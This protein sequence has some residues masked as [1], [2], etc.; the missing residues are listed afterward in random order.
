MSVSLT[1]SG[2]AACKQL[3]VLKT[4]IIKNANRVLNETM[5]AKINDLNELFTS[6]PDFNLEQSTVEQV[7]SKAC[8][9]GSS[10]EIDVPMTADEG[11][12]NNKKRKLSEISSSLSSDDL[13]NSIHISKFPRSTKKVTTNSVSVRLE[14]FV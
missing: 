4:R 10:A 6:H 13:Q 11:A 5:P 3:E 8:D 12:N 14:I 1:S 2:L 9:F 7:L